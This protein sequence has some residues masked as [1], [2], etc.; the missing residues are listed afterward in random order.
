MQLGEDV[1]IFVISI[2]D[3]DFPGGALVAEM[4][5]ETKDSYF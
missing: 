3:F 2:W 4:N 1:L 5:I